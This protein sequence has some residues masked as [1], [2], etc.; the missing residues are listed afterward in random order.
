MRRRETIF[1]LLLAAVFLLAAGFFF[2][3]GSFFLTRILT[4]WIARSTGCPIVVEQAEFRPFSG[5]LILYGFR[6]G[7][8]DRPF[9]TVRRARGNPQFH[10]LIRGIID[11]AD[12]ELHGAE[13]NLCRDAS[14]DWCRNELALAAEDA[15]DAA[16]ADGAPDSDPVQ[17]RISRLR[18]EDCRVH[19]S[20][21]DQQRDMAWHFDG[22]SGEMDDFRNGGTMAVKCFSPFRITGLDGVDFSGR[23]EW[24]GELKLDDEL[25][26][27]GLRG[28][29]VFGSLSGRIDQHQMDRADVRCAVDVLR[30][31]SGDWDLRHFRLVQQKWQKVLSLVEFTGIIPAGAG[32]YQLDFRRFFLSGQLLSLLTDMGCG[33]RPGEMVIDGHG[34][35]SGDENHFAADL[36]CKA[37]R[38]SGVAQFGQVKVML[39]D[40]QLRTTQHF[41]IDLARRKADFRNVRLEILS[42]GQQV[43]QIRKQPGEEHLRAEMQDFDLKLLQFLLPDAR[44]FR[45][46]EGRLSGSVQLL[47]GGLDESITCRAALHLRDLALQAGAWQPEGIGGRI[48][49][50]F[51]LPVSGGAVQ[52]PAFRL[53]TAYRDGPLLEVSAAGSLPVS[54]AKAALSWRFDGDVLKLL[55]MF[56]GRVAEDAA[57]IA[58]AFAPLKAAGSGKLLFADGKMTIRNHQVQ[59]TGR[60]KSFLRL[61]LQDRDF[62]RSPRD[63]HPRRIRWQAA[64][65]AQ[66]LPP[67]PWISFAGGRYTGRGGIAVYSHFSELSAEGEVLWHDLTGSLYRRVFEKVSGGTD[68][69]LNRD[70]HGRYTL[71]RSSLFCRVDGNPAMRMECVGSGDPATGKFQSDIRVRYIN[72]YFLNILFPGRFRS[73]QLAGQTRIGGDFRQMAWDAKGFFAVDHLRSPGASRAVKGNLQYEFT[74]AGAACKVPLCRL[75]LESGSRVLADIQMNIS[76]PA[77]EKKPIKIHLSASPLDL[78]SLYAQIGQAEP[79][80]DISGPERNKE[81]MILQTG[82]RVKVMQLDLRNMS[83]GAAQKF[84]LNGSL[85]F[86]RNRVTADN[87]L[88]DVGNGRFQ[89]GLDGMDFPTGMM[90]SLHGK[91][92][93]PFSLRPFAALFYPQSG[94]EGVVTAGDWQLNFRR[95]FSDHWGEDL[96]GQCRLVFSDVV[97]PVNA[98]NGPLSRVLLLPVETIVRADQLIPETWDVRKHFETLWK[99]K[100]S[101]DSPF[102]DLQFHKGELKVSASGGDLQVK[103]LHFA[104]APL[105]R[106]EVTGKMRLTFPYELEIDS[107]VELCGVQAKLPIRGQ[108]NSPRVETWK[109][110]AR[111]PDK[112]LTGWLEVFNPFNNEDGA[113]SRIPL[114]SPFIRLLRDVA[115]FQE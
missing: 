46:A 100:L 36:V 84:A 103:K 22:I 28:S 53:E 50:E 64:F 104:G 95:L 6:L 20:T 113:A 109:V 78:S 32:K 105:S 85:V 66:L 67:M 76:A 25:A 101:A 30:Q 80:S 24:N 15:D 72:E 43:M 93:K 81:R 54:E 29:F 34:Q 47:P 70:R 5:R 55:H 42:G 73:G 91:V 26:F 33:I 38:Q 3:T 14:G 31:S 99:Y 18:V 51:A 86:Q 62:A 90:L 102:A 68:F 16:P 65:P 12:V 114:I 108:L 52:V 45:I 112:T 110:L 60:E 87:M 23:M 75:R 59:L 10:H 8:P 7:R 9:L 2:F 35:I 98:A 41:A 11:F 79:A 83:W 56:R 27:R 21:H 74:R 37:D 39:P 63:L 1:A 17:V 58:G 88:L 4:P 40:F 97:L 71:N 107:D 61:D 48:S 69:S 89:W 92:L 94:L 96:A 82:S 106:M 57:H 13:L 111:M 115:G 77:E 19:V 49:G 44:K